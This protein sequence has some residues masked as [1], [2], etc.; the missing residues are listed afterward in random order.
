MSTAESKVDLYSIP[1]LKNATDDEII[2]ILISK[3]YT[4]QFSLVDARLA[5][6]FSSVLVALVVVAYDYFVGFEAAKTYTAIGVSIYF[7]LNIAFT[8]WIVFIEKGT[9]F[10]GFK[11]DNKIS[12]AS[13]IKKY[14]PNYVIRI[15]NST[16]LEKTEAIKHF[17]D[18]FDEEGHIVQSPLSQWLESIISSVTKKDDNHKSK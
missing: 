1:D 13:S 5:I 10:Q 6:G 17:A 2:K 3:G 12:V 18:F 14:V 16:S 11:D 4:Q 7:A 15:E 9:I 8:G